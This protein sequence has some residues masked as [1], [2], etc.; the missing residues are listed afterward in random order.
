MHTIALPQVTEN[1][2]RNTP[3]HAVVET[4]EELPNRGTR[5]HHPGV[6]HQRGRSGHN[7]LQPLIIRSRR[8]H[9]LTE[10]MRTW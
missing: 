7:P 1:C 6:K 8:H 5:A 4:G 10:I 3:S 2:V 9:V